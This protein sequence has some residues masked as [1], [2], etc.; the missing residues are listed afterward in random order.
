MSSF[1]LYRAELEFW[2]QSKTKPTSIALNSLRNP[3]ANNHHSLALSS[4][5]QKNLRCS[6]A[7]RWITK[8]GSRKT[9]S[10]SAALACLRRQ[11]AEVVRR[12]FPAP[13]FFALRNLR[14]FQILFTDLD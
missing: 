2:W 14:N 5:R 9:G 7:F 13:R 11:F 1:S 3:P 8:K 6:N 4:R 12:N 10:R